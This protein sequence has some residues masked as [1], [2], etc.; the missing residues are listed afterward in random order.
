MFEC[1]TLCVPSPESFI[2]P[3]AVLLHVFSDLIE[4][5]PKDVDHSVFQTFSLET[6]LIRLLLSGSRFEFNE[7]A[8]WGGDN[9]IRD[10]GSDAHKLVLLA[11]DVVPRVVEVGEIHESPFPAPG[12]IKGNLK[13]LLWELHLLGLT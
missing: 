5:V 4:I 3:F 9:D 8:S 12:L 11:L 6:F 10:S 13:P 7:D 1:N 2:P